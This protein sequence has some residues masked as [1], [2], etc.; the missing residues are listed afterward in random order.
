MRSYPGLHLAS[1]YLAG[2]GIPDCI[3]RARSTAKEIAESENVK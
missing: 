2:V 3:E 1:N